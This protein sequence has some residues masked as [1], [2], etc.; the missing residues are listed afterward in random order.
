MGEY[1]HPFLDLFLGIRALVDEKRLN[2]PDDLGRKIR[3]K[4]LPF[5][6]E[7]PLDTRSA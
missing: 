2:E 5:E 6:I 3:A 1:R 7:V 4:H